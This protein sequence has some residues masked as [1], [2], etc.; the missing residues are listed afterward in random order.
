MIIRRAAEL[1]CLRAGSQFRAI[2]ASNQ[3]RLVTY[4]LAA[5]SKRSVECI[6]TDLPVRLAQHGS[7]KMATALLIAW[8]LR[9]V[10]D[11]MSQVRRSVPVLVSMLFASLRHLP[12]AIGS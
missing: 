11:R 9:A 12:I 8:V 5:L 7:W 4:Y 2:Y 6:I 1:V 3:F 10:A